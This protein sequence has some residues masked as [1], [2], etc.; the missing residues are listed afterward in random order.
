MP[1]GA[2]RGLEVGH[3]WVEAQ[4]TGAGSYELL[5]QQTVRVRAIAATTVS[6]DGVLAMT[7]AVGEV[8]LFNAGTG[9]ANDS[10]TRVTLDIVGSAAVQIARQV[11]TG[12][13]NK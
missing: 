13:R 12:R 3:V 6:L 9:R 4:A 2:Q 10:K 11:E 1:T 7:M 5:P 8:E